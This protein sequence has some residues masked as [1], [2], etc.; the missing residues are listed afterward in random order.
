MNDPTPRVRD[1]GVVCHG[2][3]T[4]L[5]CGMPEADITAHLPDITRED[6]AL[7]RAWAVEALRACRT[8]LAEA[9]SPP[10]G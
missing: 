10:A 1:T 6:I 9:G 2:V 7:V 8:P 3:A 4:M 5:I